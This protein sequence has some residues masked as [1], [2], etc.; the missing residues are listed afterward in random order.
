VWAVEAGRPLPM[1]I[2]LALLAGLTQPAMPSA[3]RALWTDLV[4]AGPQRSA[5]YSY[6]AISLE[7]FFIIG[8]AFAAFLIVL[9]WPGT[10]LVVAAAAMVLG[11][12]GFALSTPVRRRHAAP[13]GPAQGLL[14][15]LG[16]PAM[17]TVALA[18]A[19]FGIVIG[20]VE[21][22]VPAVTAAAGSPALGGILISA[23]SVASVL[24]GVLYSMRPW[25]RPLQLRMPVLLAG[26]AVMVGA[27]SL[28]GINDSLIVLTIAMLGA[29]AL[30][31]PQVTAHSIAVDTAAPAGSAT[32]AFGWVV[33]AA[34]LGLAIGQ[35]VAGIV[36]EAAGPHA[37]FVAGGVSGLLLAG[38]LWARRHTVI[39]DVAPVV[40]RE[41]AVV[42]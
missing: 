10:G 11:A 22:G 17:R 12:L 24:A 20:T 39:P 15:A 8:P 27:M 32:E 33:T 19:G 6:E 28:A 13:A 41:A 16:R 3:S 30:I 18:S 4:P 5:A 21:V 34:T 25:P 26:F 42:G 7:V 29:G 40:G 36:V 2:G 31:T 1:L 38:V 37:A 14:G 23:W 35:S 9:P